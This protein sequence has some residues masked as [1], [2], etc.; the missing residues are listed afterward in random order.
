MN[1]L[2]KCTHEM[3]VICL[4]FNKKENKEKTK[5]TR[6]ETKL[7]KTRQGTLRPPPDPVR[8]AWGG[9]AGGLAY[10]NI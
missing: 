7:I 9:A 4:L 1:Q 5:I 3:Y 6:N 10:N 2:Y 8:A